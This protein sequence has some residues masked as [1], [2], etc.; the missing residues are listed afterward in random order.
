MIKE[1]LSQVEERTTKSTY[2]LD[3]GFERCEDKGENSAPKFVYSSNYHKE[4]EP[5]KPTKT[6]YLS[7]P[8][9]SF[10]P[11]RGV[12]KNTPNPSEEVYIWMFCGRAGHLENF[13]FGVRERRRG[14]W[15]ML[16]THT[17]MSLLIF[18]LTFL[19]LLR[20]IFLVDLTIA[21]MVLVHERVVLCLDALVS[22]CTLIMVFIPCVG[23][24][25]YSHFE[26]SRFDSPHFP[27]RGSHLTHSNGEVQRIVKTS[28]GRMVKC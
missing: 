4:E 16:E 25:I 18:C 3:A 24:L 12:K 11:K 14:V 20:L 1:D 2:K 5:L 19:L 9:P 10:N 7:N 23:T 8:K 15:T 27:R 21:H 6:H 22:T 28:S 26:L 13:A 17:M